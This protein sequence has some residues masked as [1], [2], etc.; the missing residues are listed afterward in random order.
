M[1][2]K[3]A[4]ANAGSVSLNKYIS[5]TGFCSRRQADDYIAQ[6]R[7][8]INDEPAAL[9]NRVDTGDVV[10]IDGGAIVKRVKPLYIPFHKPA[11]ITSTTDRNDRTNIVDFIGHKER[12]F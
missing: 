6:G 4:Y 7:G 3:G 10:G 8:T 1:P 12:I 9:G 11:G 2:K 5:D